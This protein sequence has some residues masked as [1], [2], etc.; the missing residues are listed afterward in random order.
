MRN[1]L[2]FYNTLAGQAA[3]AIEN[4]SLFDSL[5]RANTELSLAYDAT[6]EGWSR[7][8]D[9]RDKETEGHTQRV[10]AMTLR[11]GEA[12]GL[13]EEELVQ[14]RWGALLHDIGKLGVPDQNPP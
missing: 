14:V 2:T 12:F 9:M 6:I 7:A 11:L 1:G 3:I 10:T 13:S 5:Q 8:L 4:T